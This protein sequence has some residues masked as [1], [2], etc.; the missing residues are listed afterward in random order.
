MARMTILA[1]LMAATLAGPAFAAD[2]AVPVAPAAPVSPWDFAFG[3]KAMSDYNFRGISQSARGPAFSAYGEL[4]YNWLYG[5]AAFWTTKL[6]NAPVG[7]IDLY[8]GIR[9]VF[10]N[11]TLDLG[12]M[13][14]LYTPERQF[15]TDYVAGPAPVIVVPPTALA[16]IWTP[17]NT[18][19]WEFYGKAGYDFT[20]QLNIGAAVYYAPN[21]LGTGA[22]GTYAEL[23]AK[24][25]LPSD[26]A[27]SG[28]IGHY[29]LGTTS[30]LPTGTNFNIKDYLYWNAGVSWTYKETVT[31]DLRYHGTNLN[32]TD[33]FAT[34]SDYRGVFS[35][36]GRSN[37]CGHSVV[38]TLSVDLQWSKLP[39]R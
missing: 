22:S 39:L 21:W 4:R 2:V 34:T 13:Y 20:P 11:L 6:P 27:I 18:D 25:K 29:W 33:C 31:L 3:A 30:F 38:A 36:S 17:K 16:G 14:Y 5:G 7:E 8:A 35:G 26:F 12:V 32:S 24:Y 10:G 28:A 9:P 15:I 23:N 1:G 19:F 37:W